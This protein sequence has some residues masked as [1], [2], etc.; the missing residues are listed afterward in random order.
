MIDAI[1]YEDRTVHRCNALENKATGMWEAWVSS[2]PEV[3]VQGRTPEE[4]RARL[5]WLM[6]DITFDL[7]RHSYSGWSQVGA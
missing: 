7:E 5:I 6:K 4:A 1:E 3:K 2:I